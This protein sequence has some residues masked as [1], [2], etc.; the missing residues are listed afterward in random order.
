MPRFEIYQPPSHPDQW[1]WRKV[2][3][4]GDVIED[5]PEGPWDTDEEAIADANAVLATHPAGAPPYTVVMADAALRSAN[6]RLL[7]VTDAMLGF[8]E[9]VLEAGV[10]KE[11]GQARGEK[12]VTAYK[13]ER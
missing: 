12:L 4:A 10:L 3:D 5:A 2:T 9:Y 6:D 8:M 13:E 7:K 1:T 11:K